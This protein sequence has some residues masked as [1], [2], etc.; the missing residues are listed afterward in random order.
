MLRC[1]ICGEFLITSLEKKYAKNISS[2]FAQFLC[3]SFSSRTVRNAW[4]GN[5]G[6]RVTNIISIPR[7]AFSDTFCEESS[8]REDKRVRVSLN[9]KLRASSAV[10]SAPPVSAP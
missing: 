3:Q 9:S 4:S 8:P 6:H 7:G 5:T 10:S 1:N 2:F